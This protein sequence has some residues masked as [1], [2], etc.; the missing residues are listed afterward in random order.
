MMQIG[1]FVVV[2]ETYGKFVR[3]CTTK[4]IPFF[5]MHYFGQINKE[6]KVVNG[7]YHAYKKA[8]VI[9]LFG[10][11]R[12]YDE[13]LYTNFTQHLGIIMDQAQS[14]AQFTTNSKAESQ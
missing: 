5:K 4:L 2:N 13:A 12:I 8:V 7:G 14:N 1:T 9:S 11:L 10:R 3:V 6:Q